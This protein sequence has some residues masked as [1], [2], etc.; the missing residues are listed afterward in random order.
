MK[1]IQDDALKQMKGGGISV[2]GVAVIVGVLVF[3]SGIIDGMVHP[4]KCTE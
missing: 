2:L 4:K 3:V 1:P